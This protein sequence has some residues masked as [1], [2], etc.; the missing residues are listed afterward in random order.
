MRQLGLLLAV[1]A[2]M[3]HWLNR[4]LYCPRQQHRETVT[5]Q[6]GHLRY[7]CVDCGRSEELG[8]V[9]PSTYCHTQ[10]RRTA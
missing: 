10:L 8:Q 9:F 2:V 7:R 3:V 1:N 6:Y 4:A 5:G